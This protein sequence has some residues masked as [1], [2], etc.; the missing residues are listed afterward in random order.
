[1]RDKR[2]L[3]VDS[4]SYCVLYPLDKSAIAEKEYAKAHVFCGTP[5]T[6]SARSGAGDATLLSS[7]CVNTSIRSVF[8]SPQ[9]S[10]N[11]T[12]TVPHQASAAKILILK[13]KREKLRSS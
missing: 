6:S 7:S 10:I 2:G 9:N 13:G 1:M 8:K 3:I 11:T 4:F 12:H 5:T